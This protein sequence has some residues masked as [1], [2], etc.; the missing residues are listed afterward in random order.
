[1]DILELNTELFKV[2][3]EIKELQKKESAILT[4]MDKIKR[5]LYSKDQGRII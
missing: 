3:K 1:M 2:Q 5:D 4:K